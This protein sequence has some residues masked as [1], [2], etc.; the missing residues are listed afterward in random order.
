MSFKYEDIMTRV[1]D[2][3]PDKYDKR[4]GS[5]LWNLI[6]PVAQELAIGYHR[7]D[8]YRDNLYLDTAE[9]EYLSRLA[10][11]FGVTRRPAERTTG[12]LEVSYRK[13]PTEPLHNI[14]FTTRNGKH[15]LNIIPEIVNRQDFPDGSGSRTYK[16]EESVTGEGIA[17]Y[18]T[19][20]T[21]RELIDPQFMN[22]IPS[23]HIEGFTKATVVKLT[24]IGRDKEDDNTLR[25][26]TINQIHNQAAN[27]NVAQ[28]EKWAI[29]YPGIGGVDVIPLED[30]PGTVGVYISDNAGGTPPSELVEAFQDYLG[31]GGM[32]EGVAPIG[33]KV[34]VK[35]L[36][37]LFIKVTATVKGQGER[38]EENFT[39]RLKD[40][41]RGEAKAAGEIRL[42]RIYDL[43]HDTP[44]V[45]SVLDVQCPILGDGDR[46][47]IPKLQTPTV[48]VG[49]VRVNVK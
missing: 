40:Y 5:T 35:P 23:E 48:G 6:A 14:S 20:G 26:R 3:L 21:S 15:R 12:Y 30:G 19:A 2:R 17:V 1:L 43:L 10:E 22:L 32:G 9:G 41:L 47:A 42:Y 49:A 28:Y 8:L 7:L 11:M 37:P 29:N 46:I 31:R 33:A 25:E 36:K 44:G 45:D 27:G 24:N 34:T 16:F 38:I 4:Q 39:R 18:H 13:A